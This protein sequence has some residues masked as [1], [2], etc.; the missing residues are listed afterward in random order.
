MKLI[1]LT[2]GWKIIKFLCRGQ[3][4]E[5]VEKI[6]RKKDGRQNSCEISDLSETKEK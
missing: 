1:L 3:V 2:D 6:E 5:V 4:S